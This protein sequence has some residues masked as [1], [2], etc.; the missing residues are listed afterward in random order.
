MKPFLAAMAAVVLMT[1]S[2]EAY[3]IL[4]PGVSSCADWTADR[5]TIGTSDPDVAYMD[6]YWV[7]GFIS[8]VGYLGHPGL[9]PLNGQSDMAV[10]AWVDRYCEAHPLDK[11][12]VAAA[13]FIREH[14]H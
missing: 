4:G 9:D 3:Q 11:I 13:A 8:G 6:L 10:A 14:P 7:L 1:G 12:A 5:R 2:V